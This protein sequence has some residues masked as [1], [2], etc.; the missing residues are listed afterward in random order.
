MKFGC[1]KEQYIN[2]KLYLNKF[3]RIKSCSGSTMGVLIESNSAYTLLKPAI[4]C[5]NMGD[6]LLYREETEIPVKINN[7]AGDIYE[8]ISEQF[9]NYYKN[10]KLHKGKPVNSDQLE[11]DF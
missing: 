4:V 11:F 9:Y 3:V 6:D 5:E 8:T 2:E 10:L 7:N 1:I